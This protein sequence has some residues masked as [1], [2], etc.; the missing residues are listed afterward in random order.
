M[1]QPHVVVMIIKPG[2]EIEATVEGI[3]GPS[4][5]QATAWLDDLGEVTTHK[6]TP[7]FYAHTTS[8]Q[9]TTQEHVSVGNGE[10]GGSHGTPW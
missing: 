2:G 9:T 8:Q 6:R 3:E 7:D 5:E 1:T 4:C 10:K